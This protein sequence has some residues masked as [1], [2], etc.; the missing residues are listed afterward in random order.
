MTMC[1]RKLTPEGDV[2]EWGEG[3]LWL[4][5]WPASPLELLAEEPLTGVYLD[6]KVP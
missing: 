6:P 1:K 5:R 3:Q 4:D 2:D